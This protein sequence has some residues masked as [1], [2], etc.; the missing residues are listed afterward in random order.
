MDEHQGRTGSLTKNSS[1]RITTEDDPWTSAMIARAQQQQQQQQQ[2]LAKSSTPLQDALG[3]D[4]S[5]D[6]VDRFSNYSQ[7]SQQ[8]QPQ[9]NGSR[10]LSPGPILDV[11][12]SNINGVGEGFEFGASS[13][14]M[15]HHHHRQ[16]QQQ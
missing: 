13:Y 12:G 15:S 11:P 6:N 8:I 5:R 4:Y 7:L 16:Q 1:R 3:H 9:E 2:Q 10:S 14:G